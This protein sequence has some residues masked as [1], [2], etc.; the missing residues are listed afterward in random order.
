MSLETQLELLGGDLGDCDAS[1]YKRTFAEVK[2]MIEELSVM[3]DKDW[4]KNQPP[5]SSLSTT[6]QSDKEEVDQLMGN[7]SLSYNLGWA[8][9]LAEDQADEGPAYDLGWATL[10]DEEA[11]DDGPVYN[12]RWMALLTEG[13]DGLDEP[14]DYQADVPAVDN[15]DND[16][17]PA[18][19]LGWGDVPVDPKV[20]NLT[21]DDGPTYD[22]GWDVHPS[23]APPSPSD[24]GVDINIK[25]AL[26]LDGEFSNADEKTTN[27]MMMHINC[28]LKAIGNN[29]ANHGS[30]NQYAHAIME[31]AI[32][33][34]NYNRT[35][36]HILL[37][38]L[39]LL[40]WFA[41]AQDQVTNIGQD[42]SQ[43]HRLIHVQRRILKMVNQVITSLET[44][45]QE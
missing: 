21:S 13:V 15:T 18:Y 42:L 1:D 28:W 39:Q 24:M 6:I 20:I 37:E 16:D 35:L 38:N 40:G 29:M 32:H 23:P 22:L 14:M 34:L 9:L 11:A 43:L 27:E 4:A 30:D 44:S 41:D 19:D 17:G 25:R 3:F 36:V 33:R 8:T 45:E 10:P 12:L 31:N 5:A 2:N 26:S 7:D